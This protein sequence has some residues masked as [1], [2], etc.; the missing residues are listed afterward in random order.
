MIYIFILA[1]IK[2]DVSCIEILILV[3]YY[4]EMLT[5]VGNCFQVMVFV[6]LPGLGVQPQGQGR[7]DFGAQLEGR[8]PA[9]ALMALMG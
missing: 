9:M 7:R 5:S 8:V 3:S 1:M 4:A 2:Y 6:Q